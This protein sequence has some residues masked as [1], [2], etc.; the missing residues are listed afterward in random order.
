M[1]KKR[2]TEKA[3]LKS[4]ETI[5]PT[6]RTPTEIYTSMDKMQGL[7]TILGNLSLREFTC[8]M[9]QLDGNTHEE[10]AAM[11]KIKIEIIP[12]KIQVIRNKI[13]DAWDTRIRFEQMV[14]AQIAKR[15]QLH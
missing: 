15:E 6:P 3:L 8:L 2:K 7:A 14:L 5:Q 13:S 4:E 10:I 9:M 11:L 1:Q 12:E